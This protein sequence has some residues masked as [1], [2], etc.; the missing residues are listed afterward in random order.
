M[1]SQEGLFAVDQGVAQM[2]RQPVVVQ[3]WNGI[4]ALHAP[5]VHLQVQS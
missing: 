4:R 3:F 5:M 2:Q 1:K